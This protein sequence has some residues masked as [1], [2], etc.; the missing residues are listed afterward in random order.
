MLFVFSR[1]SRSSSTEMRQIIQGRFYGD[2][3]IQPGRGRFEQFDV[4]LAQ[5]CLPFC[6]SLWF[7][8]NW[9]TPE[10][11]LQLWFLNSWYKHFKFIMFNFCLISPSG[12]LSTSLQRVSPIIVSG[13]HLILSKPDRVRRTK[14]LVAGSE[15]MW[16]DSLS[17][18]I[19]CTMPFHETATIVFRTLKSK[20]LIAGFWLCHL[21]FCQYVGILCLQ[22]KDQ[23][24]EKIKLSLQRQKEI[25]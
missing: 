23:K 20:I 6:S 15:L 19:H 3:S 9:L 7:L 10:S 16:T 2:H 25:D 18:K 12:C 22:I 24:T 8:Y 1:K 11:F 21:G 13:Y 4:G 5:D 17:V 14:V